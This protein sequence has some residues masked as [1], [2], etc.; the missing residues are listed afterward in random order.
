MVVK[1][2]ACEWSVFTNDKGEVINNLTEDP[3][4]NLM[5][6]NSYSV[7]VRKFSL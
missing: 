3:K 6:S 7:D 1:V 4:N 5:N 2:Y